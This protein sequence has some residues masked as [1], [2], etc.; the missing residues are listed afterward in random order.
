MGCCGGSNQ[1]DNQNN[2]PLKEWGDEK[3]QNDTGVK[4][5]PL[6]IIMVAL[7]LGLIIYKFVI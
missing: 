5:N 7:L 3:K 1:S 4:Q 2:K 6:L